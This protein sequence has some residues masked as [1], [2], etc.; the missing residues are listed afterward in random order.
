MSHHDRCP[1]KLNPGYGTCDCREHDIRENTAA[2]RAVS[3]Q[4]SREEQMQQTIDI[5][6]ERLAT[7]EKQRDE[8]VNWKDQLML[9][10]NERRRVFFGDLAGIY[11][12]ESEAELATRRIEYVRA[13][14]ANAIHYCC[15]VDGDLWNTDFY[16]T[17][18]KWI[19]RDAARSATPK[20]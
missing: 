1:A 12:P 2:L 20:T 11:V 4:R 5:L 17:L 14:F 9:R 13:N 7:A 16:G 3:E 10:L 19:A 18:D 8:A 15:R 6:T